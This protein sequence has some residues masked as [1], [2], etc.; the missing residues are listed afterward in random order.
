[1]HFKTKA[2]FKFSMPV[3]LLMCLFIS[4]KKQDYDIVNLNGNKITALGHAGMGIS[5]IYPINTSESIL[6]CLNSGMDGTEFDLQ[7]TKDSILILYHSANLSDNTNLKGIVNTLYWS[8]CQNAYY[9]TPY[10]NYL[11]VPLDELFSKIKN[12]TD[13]KFTFDCKLYTENYSTEYLQ[14]Y[15]NAIVKM[16]QKYKLENNV[17]IES[18]DENF[19]T[20]FKQQEPNYKLFIYHT[21]FES[22]LAI[23]S[24]LHLYGITM[25][26]TNINKEQIEL[27][28]DNGFLVAI[29]NTHS[30]RD[31]KEAIEKNPD[32][33]QTDKPDYLLKL[34]KQ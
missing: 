16:V 22:A 6:K 14:T 7:L 28:H 24:S 27:A 18:Q 25:S 32:F 11:I 13:Y 21:E 1:M 33:I 30:R 26:T 17:Y 31:N 10:F 29:W 34:L 20:L 23:A 2:V 12:V 19:L 5:S 4:C 8:D 9:A 3:L 15:I